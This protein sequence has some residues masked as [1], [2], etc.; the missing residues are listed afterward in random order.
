M[1]AWVAED[2]AFFDPNF[3]EFWFANPNHFAQ[4]FRS[5]FWTRSL[6]FAGLSGQYWLFPY[7]KAMPFAL[8]A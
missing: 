6:Y 8:Q 7:A 2:L 5:E 3:G 4:W 1:A